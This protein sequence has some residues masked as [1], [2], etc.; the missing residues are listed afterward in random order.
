MG[1][2]KSHNYDL[3]SYLYIYLLFILL[4]DICI[5]LTA[6]T[7]LLFLICLCISTVINNNKYYYYYYCYNSLSLSFFT[8]AQSSHIYTCTIYIHLIAYIHFNVH[9]HISYAI[10]THPT[11]DI[12]HS[13][14]TSA[15]TT[16]ILI[17][18]VIRVNAG[19]RSSSGYTF[20][21]TCPITGITIGRCSHI[22]SIR[23]GGG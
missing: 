19:G 7:H 11:H 17:I 13:S 5:Y 20:V 6:Y 3:F 22:S 21:M 14:V 4:Y 8:S 1:K 10:L 15:I 18:T 12:L 23:S 9:S 16:I 2:N